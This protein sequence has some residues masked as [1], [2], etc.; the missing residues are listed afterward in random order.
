LMRVAF[1]LGLVLT[2]MTVG[3]A[4]AQVTA[5]Q[6]SAIRANCRSDFMSKCSGVTPGGKE[7]LQCLQKNVAALSAGCKT[8][9]SATLPEPAPAAAVSAPAKPAAAPKVEAAAPPAAAPA[10]PVT[11]T[12]AAAPS[13]PATANV[14]PK[15]AEA[16]K[17]RTA[18]RPPSKP[19]PVSP[20]TAQTAAAPP[21][22]ANPPAAAT[23]PTTAPDKPVANAAVALRACK[24]D[25]VR[26]C[27][28]VAFGDGRKL[29]CL[30]ERADNLTVRCRTALK[31]SAP[32]R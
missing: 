5:E 27:S 16:A 19:Q 30:N 15:P 8:A 10:A 20:P 32:I 29:A 21:A 7:A 23:A 6:Q 25:L 3:T 18:A 12:P 4:G 1:G 17:P 9:V 26:H 11:A 31:V 14:A 2:V 28:N 13:P 22:S 24:L